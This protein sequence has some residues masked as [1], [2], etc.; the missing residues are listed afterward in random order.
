MNYLAHIYL[1]GE[2]EEILTGNFIGDHVKG[3]N[4]LC[5][6]EKIRKGILLHRQIDSFTD[7]NFFFREAKKIF[8]P[9]FG[10]YAGVI[11]DLFFDHF[12]ARNWQDFSPTPLQNYTEKVHSILLS[13]YSHIPPRVRT[14][15]P[16]LIRQQRLLSYARIAGIRRSLEKMSLHTSLPGHAPE[17][18]HTL[19]KHYLFL[20]K[21]F[22]SFM[23]EI[24]SFV[25]EAFGVFP[26]RADRCPEAPVLKANIS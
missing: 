12:L 19:D 23:P 14:F 2:D 11:T 25:E 3:K 22:F 13:H 6:P 15:L 5:Y 21:N 7:S 17:A 20:E 16:F 26:Q 9:E 10:L 24:I 1:S 18:I 4:Y 8:R